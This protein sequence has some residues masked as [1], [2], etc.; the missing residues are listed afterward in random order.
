MTLGAAI[1][2]I[3]LD[4][5]LNI[6]AFSR[7]V[8]YSRQYIYELLKSEEEGGKNRK[9]Q[10]DTL[11]Q[12]CDTTGYSLKTLLEDIG[13]I[14]VPDYEPKENSVI[15]MDKGG[16]KKEY[17]LTAENAQLVKQLIAAIES[18]QQ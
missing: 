3:L 6:S 1:E 17:F 18:N 15:V 4:S 10:L 14:D 12:L 2:R 5:G 13:Y 11:K 8:G 7:Q 9:I 16:K